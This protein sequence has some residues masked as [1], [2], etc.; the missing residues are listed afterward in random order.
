LRIELRPLKPIGVNHPRPNRLPGGHVPNLQFLL[1]R[2]GDQFFA[3]WVKHRQEQAVVHAPGKVRFMG[4]SLANLETERRPTR[5]GTANSL[6]H[7]AGRLQR[8]SP[9]IS[10]GFTLIELLVVIAIIAILAGLLLPALSKAQAAAQS[11]ACKNNLKQLQLAW[12]VYADD[13]RGYVVGDVEAWIANGWYNTDG[14]VLGNAQSD[15]TADNIKT[16]KLWKY[17]GA[18]GLYRCPSDRSTVRGRPGLLRFRSYA[19]DF[20][21]NL[22]FTP[23][24]SGAGGLSPTA[25]RAGGI[26]L[27]DLNVL[28]PASNFGY[29]DVSEDSISS[30]VLGMFYDTWLSGQWYW[31][32]QPGWRHRL[33]ANSSFL[34][35]HAASHRWL[36]TP[37]QILVYGQGT[38]FAN[39]LDEQDFMWLFNRMHLGQVREQVLGLPFP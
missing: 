34:D 25:L 22:A 14:W 32:E 27:S 29:L 1:L 17:T 5:R 18:T 26:L 16:G 19:A 15:Q 2:L 31:N 35:G 3:A 11:A 28:A 6:C 24:L 12:Q 39:N 20:S 33:G 38:P 9:A 10:T 7:P 23:G 37:K 13:N 30:G 8:R 21:L 36:Y 4:P